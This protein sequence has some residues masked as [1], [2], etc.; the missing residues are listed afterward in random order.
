M[1]TITIAGMSVPAGQASEAWIAQMLAE[2]QKRGVPCVQVS[3]SEPG[4]QLA[5]SNPLGCGGGGGGGR[6]PNAIEQKVIDAWN[7]RVGSGRFSPGDLRAFAQ[8]VMRIL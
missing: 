7:R 1:I 2:G 3:V 8:D 6:Q 5:L 4:V